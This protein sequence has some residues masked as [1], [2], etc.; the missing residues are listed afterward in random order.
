MRHHLP[1]F[2]FFLSISAAVHA[3]NAAPGMTIEAD[4]TKSVTANTVIATGHVVIK[5]GPAE[6]RTDKAKIVTGE[7]EVMVYTDTFTASVK[8]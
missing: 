3:E 5:S 6:I 4:Q 2:V 1:I 8:K 7:H